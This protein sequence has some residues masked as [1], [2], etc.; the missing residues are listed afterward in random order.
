MYKLCLLI[1]I[2]L[3]FVKCQEEPAFTPK[4]RAFP[5]VIY[6]EKS[7]QVFN[8][9]DCAFTF[10]YPTYAQIEQSKTYFEEEP[11]H[12]CWFN[13]YIPQF[14]SRIHCTYSP[15]DQ[16]KDLEARKADAFR[17]TDVHNKKANYIEEL[18]IQ[19]ENQV[20]GFAFD[21]DGPAASPFQFFLT[22]STHHFLRGALYFNTQARPDSLAP[23]ID[24]VREDILHLIETFAWKTE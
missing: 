9:G 14:D 19:K 16:G 7:Y 2:G 13:L 10:E 8:G 17:M 5:R 18:I 11:G 22:D 3:I 20:S 1:L 12:P 23:V 6:P 4:P 24:F 15:I 21:I